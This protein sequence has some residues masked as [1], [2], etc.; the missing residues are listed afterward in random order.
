[1]KEPIAYLLKKLLQKNKI[2]VDNEE[3]E[4]QIL[5]HPTYP[6]LHSV[7]GVLDHFA[8]KNYALEVPKSCETLDLLPTTFLAL[9]QG[10]RYALVSKLDQ[11]FELTFDNKNKQ[12]I[13]SDFFLETWTGIIVI[14]EEEK[15]EATP[16]PKKINL[17]KVALFAAVA[18]LPIIFFLSGP[19][20]FQFLHFA[21]SFAGV[22]ICVLIV[23]HE[24]GLHSK[25]LD[26]F[27]SEEHKKS[28]CDAVMNSKGASLFGIMKFSDIGIIYFASLI[29]SWLFTIT[30][31][32]SDGLIVLITLLA[33]PFTVYSIY[34]Q[35]RVVRKWC[36]LCLSVVSVLWL[37]AMALFF[38]NLNTSTILSNSKSEALILFSFVA[39]FAAW[40]SLWPKLKKE[41]ELYSLKVEHYR[42]KR[43]FNIYESL[44]NRSES[45]NIHI[46]NRFEIVLGSKVEN[47]LLSIV[48]VTNPLCGFCKEAHQLVEGLLKRNDRATCIVIRF[49]V[50][51]D[52]N[53]LDRH[54]ALRLIEIYNNAGEELCLLAMNDIYGELP[55]TAWLNKWEEPSKQYA[56]TLATQKGWCRQN[57]INF[58]P[59]ILVNG[60][61]FPKEY[62]RMDLLYFMDELLEETTEEEAPQEAS[63][64]KVE[65]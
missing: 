34:Y 38:T 54:I 53:S 16:K 26:K 23:Q 58:T 2:E 46:D 28:S 51:E 36:P 21:L 1:M 20:L 18:M 61:S 27:C 22:A 44:I 32:G 7:T 60:Q 12:R 42:F 64:I 39:T 11:D 5:S 17:T 35:Y 29:L 8:I 10:N 13:S 40:Q 25:V 63:A 31:G 33:I 37:Q 43:S 24:L 49:N 6:S 62:N 48:V 15:Q 65:A 41:R 45:I 9:L 3:L 30:S 19:S 50:S 59:E 55:P 4:F 57:G 52:E 14:V 56:K 47:P